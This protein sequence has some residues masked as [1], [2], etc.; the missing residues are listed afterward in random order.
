MP[1]KMARCEKHDLS[2]AVEC[3][4]CVI[5]AYKAK[6]DAKLAEEPVKE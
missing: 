3:Y 1:D 5:E 4:W 2:Y 6:Q